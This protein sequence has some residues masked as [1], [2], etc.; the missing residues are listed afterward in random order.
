M[1]EIH[2]YIKEYYIGSKL[3]G[4]IQLQ[5]PDREKHGYTGR[6]LETLEQDTKFKQIY[7]KG[8]KVYTEL[9]PICGRLLGTW[10]EKINILANSRQNFTR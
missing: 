2:G 8:T 3:I 1:F 10:E 5:K 9:S 6:R 4:K 7:K